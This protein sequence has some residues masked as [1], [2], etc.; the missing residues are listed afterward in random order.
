LGTFNFAAAGTAQ[1]HHSP[2]P[3]EGVDHLRTLLLAG[4]DERSEVAYGAKKISSGC[5]AKQI[6]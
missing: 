3:A 4:D 5:L 6:A 2:D 1:Q